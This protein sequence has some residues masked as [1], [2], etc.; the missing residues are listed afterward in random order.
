MVRMI[1]YRVCVIFNCVS[2]S[3]SNLLLFRWTFADEA[4]Q[5]SENRFHLNILMIGPKIHERQST[6]NTTLKQQR[7]SDRLA[8]HVLYKIYHVAN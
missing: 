7:D 2:T 1:S 5:L 8:T 3:T 4:S 6:F